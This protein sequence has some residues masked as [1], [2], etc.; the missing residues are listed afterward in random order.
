MWNA[1]DVGLRAPRLR[2]DG[3][4]VEMGKGRHAAWQGMRILK[5]FT[6]RELHNA[7]GA[8]ESDI[9]SFCVYLT[10]AGY[11]RMIVRGAGGKPSTFQ[12]IRN[13]GPKAPQVTRL[14]CVFDPNLCAVTWPTAE[15]EAETTVEGTP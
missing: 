5:R 2:T 12:L 14:K 3:T 6:I 13:S 11:L 4:P 15:I 8:Q 7:T 9:K 10:K 1:R